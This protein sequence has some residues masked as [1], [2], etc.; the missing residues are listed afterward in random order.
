MGPRIRD[1]GVEVL[2]ELFCFVVISFRGLKKYNFLDERSLFAHAHALF[3][4]KMVGE[5]NLQ[6]SFYDF[7]LGETS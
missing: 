1:W 5:L 6:L 4:A 3:F 2:G 7:G